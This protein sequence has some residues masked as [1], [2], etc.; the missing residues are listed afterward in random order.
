M[1]DA[2][3]TESSDFVQIGIIT[4]YELLKHLRRRRLLAVLVITS[5]LCAIQLGVPLALNMP[6]QQNVKDFAMSFFGFV[7]LLIIISGAFFAGD[8]IASEFQHKTGYII[9][10]N[11]VKRTTLVLGKFLAALLSVLMVVALYYLIGVSSMLGIYGEVP[12]EIG[13]SFAYAVLYL[14]SVLGLTFFFSSVFGGTTGATLTSFF[15]L[16]MILPIVTAVSTFTGYEPWYILTYASGIITEIIEPPLE[17]VV[18]ITVPGSPITIWI[19]HPDFFYSVL[20]LLAYF[21]ITLVI[22]ALIAR[23]KEMT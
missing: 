7:N 15:M 11:P 5:V 13:V 9:F 3:A 21:I 12:Y 22:S 10:P 20:V 14:C 16:F 23:R 4:R 17:R 18:E 2:H 1:S 8:A 6:Y 19:F